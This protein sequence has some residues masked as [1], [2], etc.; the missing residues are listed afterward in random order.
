MTTLDQLDEDIVSAYTSAQVFARGRAL[1][2]AGAVRE[3]ELYDNVEL[4]AEVREGNRT[5]YPQVHFEGN[6]LIIDCD[7][8]ESK[9]SACAHAIAVLLAWVHEPASFERET[10]LDAEDFAELD[11]DDEPDLEMQAPPAAAVSLSSAPPLDAERE[12][13]QLLGQLSLAQLRDLA[14]R[15]GQPVSG[16][17]REALVKP[18]AKILSQRETVMRAWSALSRP[19]QRLLGALPVMRVNNLVFPQQAKQAF[20]MLDGKAAANFDALLVELS[21]VGLVFIYQ[22][23]LISVPSLLGMY[24]PPDTD[25]GPQP[26]DATRLKPQT[27][28]P[29]PLDFV[30]LVTRLALVIKANPDRFTTRQWPVSSTIEQQT[31]GLSGWP[32]FPA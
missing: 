2:Q 13:A 17:A 14:K 5:Y 4:E 15:H 10:D 21:S 11:V 25:F 1:Y 3:R 20:Q 23:Q 29:A 8:R 18:L 6:G 32:H 24:L 30:S 9:R 31:Y 26:D 28:A 19:A 27:A 7:C 22:Q 12:L 16:T